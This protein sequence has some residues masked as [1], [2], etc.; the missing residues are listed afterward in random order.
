MGEESGG[1]V[2]CWV[3][4][5]VWTGDSVSGP[6]RGIYRV[7][8]SNVFLWR[9]FP[10]IAKTFIERR[11]LPSTKPPVNLGSRVLILNKSTGVLESPQ[12]HSF[13]TFNTPRESWRCWCH[14]QAAAAVRA[15]WTTLADSRRCLAGCCQCRLHHQ[16]P[17]PCVAAAPA[18]LLSL[19]LRHCLVAYSHHQLPENQRQD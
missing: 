6:T 7:E 9:Q 19:L 15:C 2:L 4:L 14:S 16:T 8:K 17:L 18:L 3:L 11:Q 13:L 5:R 1:S 10:T 12:V